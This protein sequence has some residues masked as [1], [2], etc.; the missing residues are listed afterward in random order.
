[1]QTKAPVRRAVHSPSRTAGQTPRASRSPARA[2]RPPAARRQVRR[3][4]GP[5][6]RSRRLQAPGLRSGRWEQ[7]TPPFGLTFRAM[8]GM[9]HHSPTRSGRSF[10]GLLSVLALLA[11]ACFVPMAQA[12]ADSSGIEYRDATPSATGEIPT[13]EAPATTSKNDGE[14]QSPGDPNNTRAS[15]KD[16]SGEETSS[17][18]GPG[19]NGGSGP[20]TQQGNPGTL[21]PAGKIALAKS[22]GKSPVSESG[23]SG[24]GGSSPLVPILIAIAAVMAIAIAVV[25]IRQRRQRGG[26]DG[27]V[28][29]EAS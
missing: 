13:Q 16:S 14:T 19:A 22:L 23:S 24:S 20:G 10:L 4:D 17:G 7:S 28:S 1:V 29:P 6:H 8:H 5:I 25:V 3:C 9:R 11:L 2:G 27:H 18:V 15:E 26:P 12:V 21:S